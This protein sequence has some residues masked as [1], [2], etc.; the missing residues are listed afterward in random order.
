MTKRKPSKNNPFDISEVLSAPVRAV[1]NGR[2]KKMPVFEAEIRQHLAKALKNKCIAS[3][4]YLFGQAEKFNLI[5]EPKEGRTSGVLII[6]KDVP[7][8]YQDEIF[9]WRP[10][11][12]ELDLWVRSA[13]ILAR[14]FE[15]RKRKRKTKKNKKKQKQKQ[16]EQSNDK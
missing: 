3:M 14:W 1:E 16:K 5:E 9:G 6:P 12:D 11:K 8:S 15:E 10:E 7:D 2:Q 4:K 13:I